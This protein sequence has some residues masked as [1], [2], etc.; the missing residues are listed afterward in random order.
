MNAKELEKLNR[1]VR[2]VEERVDTNRKAA[3]RVRNDDPA[4]MTYR[5]GARDEAQRILDY[6][7]VEFQAELNV[8][9]VPVDTV[10]I[11]GEVL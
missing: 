6:I 3:D 2:K 4:E 5:Y 11:K 9:T 7:R 8:V 10:P 1:L